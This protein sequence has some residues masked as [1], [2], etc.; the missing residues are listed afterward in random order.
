MIPPTSYIDFQGEFRT[1]CDCRIDFE[2]QH[3]SVWLYID[4]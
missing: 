1:L 2:I 4:D 3:Q